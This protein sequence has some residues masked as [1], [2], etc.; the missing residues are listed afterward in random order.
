[1]SALSVDREHGPFRVEFKFVDDTWRNEGSDGLPEVTVWLISRSHD[2]VVYGR[3]A[4][5]TQRVLA[6]NLVQ[7]HAVCHPARLL[8]Q[9]RANVRI[10]RI[11]RVDG[12]ARGTGGRMRPVVLL[13]SELVRWLLLS[14]AIL[15]FGVIGIVRAPST[16]ASTTGKI[17]GF[18]FRLDGK[19][20]YLTVAYTVEGSDF[21]FD[22]S[23]DDRWCAYQGLYRRDSDV[24]VYYDSS[25]P[26]TATLTP[27]GALP[28]A[29]VAIGLVGLGAC[30]AYRAKRQRR[31]E[32]PASVGVV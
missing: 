5:K 16:D 15:A 25:D 12:T 4:I 3:I 8:V 7:P 22:S 2:Y 13:R 1:M 23:H 21:R 19:Q 30:G 26:G 24:V 32:R 6:I 28:M 9:R 14:L 31:N 17:A 29:S 27:R 20:C 11:V 10:C 18:G